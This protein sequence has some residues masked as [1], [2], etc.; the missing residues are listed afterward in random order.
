M[1]K[2][3]LSVCM[4]LGLNAYAQFG[5]GGQQIK[6]EDM[7]CSQKYSDLNYADDGKAFHTLDIYLPETKAEKYPVVV[8]IYGSAWMSNSGK[9][10]A[11]LGT[12]VTALLKAG[13]AVVCP[14]H[15][16][17]QDAKWPAQSHDIKAVIRWIRAH[18]DQYHFDT[19]YIATSGF[20]SGGHLASFMGA[21]SGM[22][23]GKVG[24][25][26]ID[27]EGS[28]GK[29]TR[30]SSRVFAAVDWS[31][32]IDL[33]NMDCGE[34]MNMGDNPPERALLGGVKKDEEPDKYRTL[35]PISFL[36][37]NDPPIIVFH[38]TK[39]NVVPFCQ[40]EEFAQ[41]I[42]A[43]GITT[44]FH[45]VEGGGHGFNMYTEEN[46]QR[47][48]DFL[49][50]AR[51][52]KGT[53]TAAAYEEPADAVPAQTNV[54]QSQY[55]K[56]TP[57]RRGVFRVQAPGAKQVVVDIC[58]KKYPMQDVGKGCWMAT[59][60][61]LVVGPHYYFIEV[62]GARVSD[63][64]SQAV[65]G[66]GLYASLFEVPESAE[67]SAYY[68]FHK[69]YAHGQVRLCQYWSQVENRARH[70]Y[71][72]TPAEYDKN[73]KKRYPVLYL[74]HG[75]A[76]NETGWHVQ[77]RMAH[78]LDNNIA[79]GKAEPMIVVMDNGNCDYGFGS[80]P[81]EGM[82]DFGASFTQVLTEDVI[83]FIDQTFRTRP[84]RE[85]RAMAGLSWGG[86]QSFNIALTHLDTFAHLGSFSGA[87]FALAGGDITKVYDGVF[88][89]AAR[90][91]KQLRTLFLGTGT[92]ENLGTKAVHEK[93]DAAGVKN[94]Y[95]ES[96]GTAHEWLTWRRCLNQFVGLIFKK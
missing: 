21:T 59:T 95:Y 86:L 69:D 63:P 49:N 62:D 11:D 47:M 90:V 61:P 48:V 87:I 6:P 13:Y 12:I 14:N 51:G 60:D 74:Q 83:P 3:L 71:V 35:S 64:G 4:L 70:C 96:Q 32:P 10:A 44:E 24:K 54:S 15:R 20:S 29:Y 30:E 40:G 27:V 25:E 77:G 88:A 7:H 9:G 2:L 41:E 80:K 23:T 28:V 67:E 50:R 79:E 72:Y 5:F 33:L 52:V 92:E 53:A 22:K 19:R 1:K 73:P 37:R 78:I 17:I 93:L 84:Q 89:D 81:G 36:D 26:E 94:V 75:M 56:I 82:N 68:T 57:D 85:F 43:A 34:A 66:C 8:H 65:Y 55:P 18:A 45:P 91:N 76:E 58:N 42:K 16:S 38:G 39:D 46:L 31:G